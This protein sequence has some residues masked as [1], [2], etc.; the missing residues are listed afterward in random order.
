[1]LASL[2]AAAGGLNLPT[3]AELE[4]LAQS[5]RFIEAA[6]RYGVTNVQELLPATSTSDK[7]GVEASLYLKQEKRR[8]IGTLPSVRGAIATRLCAFWLTR[9]TCVC[10]PN[11][12]EPCDDG[13][14]ATRRVKGTTCCDWHTDEGGKHLCGR[15]E[16]SA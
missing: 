16:S 9:F 1:M 12:S 3:P 7:K 2:T 11:R 14:P 4:E 10:L 8:L 13:A 5:P 15:R 6:R